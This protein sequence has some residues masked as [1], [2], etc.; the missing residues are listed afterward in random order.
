MSEPIA[1]VGMTPCGPGELIR[2]EILKLG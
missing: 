2:E 1:R